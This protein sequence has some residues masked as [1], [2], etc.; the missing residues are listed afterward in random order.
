M[1]LVEERWPSHSGLISKVIDKKILKNLMRNKLYDTL[2][3]L[4]CL[5]F[6][7]FIKIFVNSSHR[8]KYIYIIYNF[9]P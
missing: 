5:Y 8:K 9:K 7:Y 4:Y 6:N 3:I 2:F 1:A